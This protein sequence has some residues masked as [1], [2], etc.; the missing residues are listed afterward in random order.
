[1]D[2]QQTRRPDEDFRNPTWFDE[3]ETRVILA[4]GREVKYAR[5]LHGVIDQALHHL[6]NVGQAT[7]GTARQFGASP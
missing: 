6:E 1:M 5:E 4:K 3:E 2:V 7:I